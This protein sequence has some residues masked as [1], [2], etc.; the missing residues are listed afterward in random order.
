MTKIL[1]CPGIHEAELTTSFVR[2]VFN[3]D[4]NRGDDEFSEVL[5]FP[6][7]GVFTLSGFDIVRFLGDRLGNKLESPII[8]IGF[9]AGVVGA[10][11][12]AT[13]WQTMG[14]NVKAFIAIDGWGVPLIGSFPIHRLSHD[15]FT[16]WTSAI[17]GSGENSFYADPPVDHISMWRSPHQ[18]QG[19]ETS[20][21]T[22]YHHSQPSLNAAEFIL[23]VISKQ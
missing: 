6:G 15:Y 16:H 7:E 21:S 8:F 9:S 2:E 1:I 11:A 14:G 3:T 23:S 4:L 20:T 18:I 10:I 13:I 22:P 12:S 17:L 5:V 19:Y